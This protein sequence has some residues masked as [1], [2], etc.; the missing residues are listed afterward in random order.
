MR[1]DGDDAESAE[2]TEPLTTGL[3][4]YI[5]PIAIGLLFPIVAVV[6][7]FLIALYFILPV[8]LRRR[9]PTGAT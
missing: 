1:P 8:R 3:G 6:G 5:V 9:P 4:G 7:Y 2:L